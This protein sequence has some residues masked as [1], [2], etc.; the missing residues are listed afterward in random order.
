MTVAAADSHTFNPSLFLG[1][2]LSY[3]FFLCDVLIYGPPE[4]VHSYLQS[5]V[6]GR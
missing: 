6:G 4:Q 5:F 3:T 2:L 1:K